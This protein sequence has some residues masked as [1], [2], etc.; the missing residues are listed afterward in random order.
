METTATE[1]GHATNGYEGLPSMDAPGGNAFIGD[2]FANPA[3]S[4]LC[5]GFFELRAGEP[6]DY[7][8]TYDEMKVVVQG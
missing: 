4:V 2:V 1:F 5:S 6:L 8:Y 7:D 3:G